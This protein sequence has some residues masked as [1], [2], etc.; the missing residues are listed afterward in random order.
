[1]GGAGD[2]GVVVEGLVGGGLVGVDVQTGGADLAG[3]QRLQQVVLVD[4]VAA[5]G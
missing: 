5:A 2:V 3:V 4:V 1:M